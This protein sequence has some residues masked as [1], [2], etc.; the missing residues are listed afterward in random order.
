MINTLYNLYYIYTHKVA[1][2]WDNYMDNSNHP[3]VKHSEAKF[4][5]FSFFPWSSLLGSAL[6]PLG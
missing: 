4:E 5:A 3:L 2:T 6:A 1:I